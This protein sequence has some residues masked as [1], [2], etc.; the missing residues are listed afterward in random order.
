MAAT[1]VYRAAFASHDALQS[2]ITVVH[3]LG[4]APDEQADLAAAIKTGAFP[5]ALAKTLSNDG[6]F[7]SVTVANIREW[8]DTTPASQDA[9]AM[10]QAGLYSVSNSGELQGATGL[11]RLKTNVAGRGTHG[12]IYGFPLRQTGQLTGSTGQLANTYWT[13]LQAMATAL[14]GVLHV[15]T[16]ADTYDLC[17]FSRARWMRGESS[18]AFSVVTVTAQQK[19]HFLRRREIPRR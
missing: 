7:D 12:W 16:T 14:N 1:H 4:S 18:F 13:Q 15:T 11:C 8:G 17:V 2:F 3:F 9:Q 6:Q 5:T 19:V 10:S